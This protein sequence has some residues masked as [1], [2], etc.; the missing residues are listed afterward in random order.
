MFKSKLVDL[1]TGY[2]YT[3]GVIHTQGFHLGTFVL[4]WKQNP[5]PASALFGGEEAMRY[6]L[7]FILQIVQSH[8]PAHLSPGR[9]ICLNGVYNFVVFKQYLQING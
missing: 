8:E 5:F 7:V 2:K 4:L 6:L 1:F 3:V 9:A